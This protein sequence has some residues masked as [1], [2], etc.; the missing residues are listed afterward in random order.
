[1]KE[2]ECGNS[3]DSL[4]SKRKFLAPELVPIADILKSRE[5]RPG[6]WP[7]NDPL[8][9]TAAG[10]F[11]PKFIAEKNGMVIKREFLTVAENV[12]IALDYWLHQ[13]PENHP[14]VVIIHGLV[15]SG[16]SPFP[17]GI[18]DKAIYYGFNAVRVNLRSAGDT[19]SHSKTLYH[20]GLSEDVKKVLEEIDNKELAGKVYIAGFSLGGNMVLKGIG[21][22]GEQAKERIGG[23]AVMS[24]VVNMEDQN[25]NHRYEG[26]ILR[27]MKDAVRS[28][29]KT[30]PQDWDTSVLKHMKTIHDWESHYQVGE[31]PTKWGFGSIEEYYK[32]ASALPYVGQISVPALM[33]HAKDDPI[34]PASPLGSEQ[35]VGNPNIIVMLTKHGG[36]GG[37]VNAIRRGE[38]LDIHWGQNRVIQFFRLLQLSI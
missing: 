1:M 12:E 24:S 34:V 36:H 19:G 37:F 28:K 11:L 2:K 4:N 20:A 8:I 23:I 21:E 30:D 31:G 10:L 27:R 5:F 15:A 14:T 22:M 6:S 26:F 16:G 33:I 25:I 38:D 18:A 7:F 17:V 32:E 35:I 13:K 9:Q 29:A 3:Q